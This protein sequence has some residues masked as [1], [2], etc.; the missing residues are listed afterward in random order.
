MLTGLDRAAVNQM[1]GAETATAEVDHVLAASG[2]NPLFVGEVARHLATGGAPSTVPRSIREAIRTRLDARSPGCVATVRIAAIVGRTF[3]A[4][5]VATASGRPAI[6]C[7]THIDEAVATGFVEANGPAGEFRFVHALV[8]DAV[9]AT[10]GAA[11]AAGIA[12]DGGRS[13]PKI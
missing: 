7:L 5:L 3:D 11:R 8:R 13:D 10:L 4:G 9:E 1:L 6:E 2:G 12:P